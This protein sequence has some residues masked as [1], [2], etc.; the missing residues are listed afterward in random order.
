MGAFAKS[1]SRPIQGVVRVAQQLPG[2]GL[3]LLDSVPDQHF[4]QFGY[5]N[6]NDTEGIMDLIA[7]GAHI[8]LFITGRGSVI[9]S[10]VAPLI[11]VTGNSRTYARMQDDMDFNA[12][13]ILSGEQT[14]D[15]AAKALM[16]MVGDVA[17]GMQTKPEALGHREFFLMY[18]HQDTP[19]L[20]AGCH[21]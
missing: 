12:G 11:K 15:E 8:V 14:L 21:A 7:S 17:A 3:W 5:T 20:E 9:G 16:Q 4:M 2:P 18:K 1:G 10:P 6:P 19:Q 13:T